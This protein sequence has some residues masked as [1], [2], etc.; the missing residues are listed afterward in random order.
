MPLLRALPKCKFLKCNRQ[1]LQTLPSDICEKHFAAFILKIKIEKSKIHLF[2][3][4]V[5]IRVCGQSVEV[6]IE[7]NEFYFRIFNFID[8]C[9]CIAISMNTVHLVEWGWLVNNLQLTVLWYVVVVVVDVAA[10]AVS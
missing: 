2:I 8:F 1:F 6:V 4:L 5:W 3:N 7:E 10:M 9:T